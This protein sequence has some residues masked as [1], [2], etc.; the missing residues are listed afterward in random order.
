MFTSNQSDFYIQYIDPDTN[1]LRR[2]YPDFIAKMED[3][4][5]DNRGKVQQD[6]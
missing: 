4:S 5:S 6:R 1:R 3:G 2:Y